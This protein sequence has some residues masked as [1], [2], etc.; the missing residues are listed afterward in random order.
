[1][2]NPPD[3]APLQIDRDVSD[4]LD[5]KLAEEKVAQASKPRNQRRKI[6]KTEIASEIIR[7]AL[8]NPQLPKIK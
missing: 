6:T 8:R 7:R 4:L 5:L 3:K 2:A 1:M